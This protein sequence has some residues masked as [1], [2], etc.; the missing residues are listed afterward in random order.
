MLNWIKC[1]GWKMGKKC[2]EDIPTKDHIKE[3][4]DLDLGTTG[5]NPL[6]AAAREKDKLR[7]TEI[8]PQKNPGKGH[9]PLL[10]HLYGIVIALRHLAGIEARGLLTKAGVPTL[11]EGAGH[12][13][14]RGVD[15]S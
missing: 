15:L 7:G 14:G 13:E 5:M 1:A 8:I 11:E 3:G 2:M 12:P 10:M 6:L 4:P 9:V